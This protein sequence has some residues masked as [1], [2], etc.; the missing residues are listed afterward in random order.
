M[1][2]DVWLRYD[3]HWRHED[4]RT[5]SW[6]TPRHYR[7]SSEKHYRTSSEK[8]YRTSS[9]LQSGLCIGH[10]RRWSEPFFPVANKGVV[11]A[12][13]NI[14]I[15]CLFFLR[16]FQFFKAC[17]SRILPSPADSWRLISWSSM[18]I[19]EHS[20][21]L[22]LRNRPMC[23][24]IGAVVAYLVANRLN[25][26]RPVRIKLSWLKRGASWCTNSSHGPSPPT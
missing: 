20:V 2:E 19:G 13:T 10:H 5:R 15:W 6:A 24:P 18:E 26:F 23:N 25:E 1:E 7:T 11:V 21:V 22:M 17:K 16:I 14:C 9:L 12:Q 3:I 4:M 8:H